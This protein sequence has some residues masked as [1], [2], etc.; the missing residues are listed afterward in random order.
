MEIGGEKPRSLSSE[1]EER[2]VWR[3]KKMKIKG[4]KRK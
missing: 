1:E 3:R 4:D 2:T